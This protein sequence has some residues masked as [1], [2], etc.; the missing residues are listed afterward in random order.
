[1]S[2]FKNKEKAS[3]QKGEDKKSIV[4]KTMGVL[5]PFGLITGFYKVGSFVVKSPIRI[6]NYYSSG[7]RHIHEVRRN[8]TKDLSF[9][10]IYVN[11]FN[12]N[13]E[14]LQKAYSNYSIQAW[15]GII[16]FFAMLF[17]V[18]KTAVSLITSG[19][20]NMLLSMSIIIAC[21]AWMFCFAAYYF[22]RAFRAYQL[23]ERE[24]FKSGFINRLVFLNSIDGALP[25]PFQNIKNL[26]AMQKSIK[27][28]KRS[29]VSRRERRKKSS[30]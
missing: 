10:E 9:D 27:E 25:S 6:Y 1:M 4:R 23:K 19:N 3:L 12:R 16:G 7:I 18:I 11:N 28:E 29:R 13:E 22:S 24:L 5:N 2:I 26:H 15:I 8:H 21:L 17:I 14:D 30:I 20:E